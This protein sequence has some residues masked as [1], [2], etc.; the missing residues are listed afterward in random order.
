M[1]CHRTDVGAGDDVVPVAAA[2]NVVNVLSLDQRAPSSCNILRILW[3]WHAAMELPIVIGL[4][5]D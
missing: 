1:F 2:R 3:V 4:F 5:G